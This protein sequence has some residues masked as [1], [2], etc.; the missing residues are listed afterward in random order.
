MGVNTLLATYTS[1]LTNVL[2]N[3]MCETQDKL[4]L[5]RHKISFTASQLNT[6]IFLVNLYSK[7]SYRKHPGPAKN[8]SLSVN[9]FIQKIIII[10]I[11]QASQTVRFLQTPLHNEIQLK[12]AP[13]S[14]KTIRYQQSSI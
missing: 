9:F 8:S 12:R 3:R 11:T 5:L 13:K 4:L 1:K 2:V 10:A 6:C 7:H 14:A